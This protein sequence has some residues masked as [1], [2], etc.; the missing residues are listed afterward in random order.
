MKRLK[1]LFWL[2][3]GYLPIMLAIISIIYLWFIRVPYR[4]MYYCYQYDVVCSECSGIFNSKSDQCPNCGN[5]V[6]DTGTILIY[7]HCNKCNSSRLYKNDD[8]TV[9]KDC[10]EVLTEEQTVKFA[11]LGYDSIPAYRK[12]YTLDNLKRLLNGRIVL[13]FIMLLLSPILSKL[14]K[15]HMLRTLQ[16]R[17]IKEG[18]NKK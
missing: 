17:I 3:L 12:A 10:G 1:Y 2:G 11:D 6:L 8:S 14:I 4:S 7:K 13:S 9:C 18:L 15:V 5:N 16:R